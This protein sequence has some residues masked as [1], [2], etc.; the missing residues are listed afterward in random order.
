MSIRLVAGLA[1]ACASMVFASDVSIKSATMSVVESRFGFEG[2]SE[3]TLSLSKALDD[4]AAPYTTV[5]VAYQA[6]DGA[7]NNVL[8]ISG[9]ELDQL[10]CTWYTASLPSNTDEDGYHRYTVTLQ[11]NSTCS[12]T[13][14]GPIWIASVREGYG[15]C[16]TMDST[17][18]LQG[19]PTN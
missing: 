12:N 18:V 8:T 9:T 1:L 3:V 19:S 7:R 2:L 15:W 16:G 6:E 14:E 17:M 5:T 13:V 4:A 11:D 10:G